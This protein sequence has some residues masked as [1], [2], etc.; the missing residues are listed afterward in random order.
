MTRLVLALAIIAAV[1]AGCGSDTGRT[2]ADTE[3]VYLDIGGLKYQI[4][5]SRYINPADTEDREYLIGAPDSVKQPAPDETLFGVWV[6][7][8]N[9]SDKTRPSADTWEIHDT[10]DKI[11]R[12]VPIDTA[13]N[14]FVWQAK[15]VPPNTILPLPSSA[16]GQGPTQG[17]LLLF[18]LKTDSLQN[19]PLELKFSHGQQG[20]AGVYKIDV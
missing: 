11:Y 6:R 18:K 8:Q 3:G 17:L 1:V 10:Q 13:I 16:A 20:Q 19:R 14:P 9:V 15:D 7:V 4:E 2:E 12:P 5:M